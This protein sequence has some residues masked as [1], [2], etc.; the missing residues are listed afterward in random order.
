MVQAGSQGEAS[1]KV[2]SSEQHS[3]TVLQSSAQHH[4]RPE[5]GRGP[6]QESNVRMSQKHKGL[7][8]MTPE[9]AGAELLLSADAAGVS[10]DPSPPR[11]VSA[12]VSQLQ[13]GLR[14]AHA[15]EAGRGLPG[16]SGM[17]APSRQETGAGTLLVGEDEEFSVNSG[18][19]CQDFKHP[20]LISAVLIITIPASYEEHRPQVPRCFC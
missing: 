16:S 1:S 9:G 12:A 15:S 17:Q 13:Q 14:T 5:D 2:S 18:E 4:G 20:W 3:T 11:A 8:L 10:A 19:H 6:G 7:R